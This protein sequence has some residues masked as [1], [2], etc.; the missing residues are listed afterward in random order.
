M[1]KFSKIPDGF[2][3]I[4]PPPPVPGLGSMGGSN[5]KLRTEQD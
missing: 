4:F 3:G 5:S 2:V 1:G